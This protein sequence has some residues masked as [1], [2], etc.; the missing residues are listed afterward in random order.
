MHTLIVVAH[1]CRESLTHYLAKTVVN[2]LTA[3]DAE[4]TVDLLDLYAEKF[5]PVLS[6]LDMRTYHEGGCA[7]NDVL[8]HQKRIEAAHSVVLVFPIHW[9][10]MP[11]MLKGWVDRVFTR[12]W[13]FDWSPETG[14]CKKLNSLKVYVLCVGGASSDTYQH[15]G[16]E[17]AISKVIGEGLFGYVGASVESFDVLGDSESPANH[18]ELISKANALSILITNK[19]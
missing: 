13:A 10:G 7:S 6:A 17:A 4:H 8:A 19:S 2:A 3:S 12:G 1:P 11:A 5:N 15:Q 16:Y 18:A 14:T 9:W